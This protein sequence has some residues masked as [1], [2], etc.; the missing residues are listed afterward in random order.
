MDD[1]SGDREKSLAEQLDLM[2]QMAQE[3]DNKHRDLEEKQQHLKIEYVS[4]E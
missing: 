1:G 3:L 2:T 4:Q